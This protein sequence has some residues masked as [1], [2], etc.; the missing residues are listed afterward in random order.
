MNYRVLIFNSSILFVSGKL[1]E[2]IKLSLDCMKFDIPSLLSSAFQV[3]ESIFMVFWNPHSIEKYKNTEKGEIVNFK[4]E[5]IPIY[6]EI[7]A[8]LEPLIPD[9]FIKLL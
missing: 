5:N 4:Y 1:S 7:K 3:F 9:M 2:V 8:Y 6:N